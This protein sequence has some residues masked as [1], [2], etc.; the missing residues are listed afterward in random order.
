VATS[1][2]GTRKR[3]M[4]QIIY[5][6]I[7]FCVALSGCSGEGGSSITETAPV[8]R[9]IGTFEVGCIACTPAP[10]HTLTIAPN[11]G[12]TTLGSRDI[13][14]VEL[15]VDQGPVQTLTAPN[16]KNTAGQST[17]VF[18]IPQTTRIRIVEFTR[19]C[20]P[21]LS[22]EMT[23][24]DVGGFAFKKYIGSCQFEVFGAFSDYGEKTARIQATSSAPMRMFFFRSGV[25]GY[26]DGGSVPINATTTLTLKARAADTL[27]AY[28]PMDENL[29]TSTSS[30]VSIEGEGGALASSSV[31][32]NTGASAYAF[33]VCCGTGTPLQATPSTGTKTMA[34]A[35]SPKKYGV[36]LGGPL[37]P[38][39]VHYRVFDPASQ[40]VVTEFRGVGAGYT[41][42]PVSVKTGYEL[43][44]EASPLYAGTFVDIHI[45]NG[46]D[47]PST[48][49]SLGIATSNRTD[50]PAR[51]TVFCCS[52]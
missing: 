30:S 43:T 45:T 49:N 5:S 9:F 2:F 32:N 14:K 46:A 23:V 6:A 40:S 13:A 50:V 12:A 21:S 38:F 17:W 8:I 7:A 39:N 25:G 10:D 19:V 44:L 37:D 26:V 3:T 41:E 4:K 11:T 35:V 51:L 27:T 52:P 48:L 28:A 31:A 18:K 22:L 47:S 36:P 16:S 1:L 34:F 15:R 29:S 24:T 42:W 33:L 20:S